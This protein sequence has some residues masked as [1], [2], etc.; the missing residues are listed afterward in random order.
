MDTVMASNYIALGL[1]I[2]SVVIA[3]LPEQRRWRASRH[4]GV[5]LSLENYQRPDTGQMQ[6]RFIFSNA[7]PAVARNVT[8]ESFDTFDVDDWSPVNDNAHPARV[9][10]PGQKHAILWQQLQD[11]R[12]P[13]SALVSWSDEAGEHREEFAAS[14]I[15][16]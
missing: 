13:G 1:G 15:Y 5:S 16:L 8:I 7:G 14:P 9:V 2:L 12:T 6:A 11:Q 3:L 10:Q 4:A